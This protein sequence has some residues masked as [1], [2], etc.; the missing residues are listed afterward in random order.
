[1]MW[2][3]NSSIARCMV[4]VARGR[5]VIYAWVHVHVASWCISV[6]ISEGH[7]CND[8]GAQRGAEPKNS[9]IILV[10]SQASGRRGTPKPDSPG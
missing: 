6:H 5:C 2:S 10:S 8:V 1:M 7:Y 3:P 4:P 9:P